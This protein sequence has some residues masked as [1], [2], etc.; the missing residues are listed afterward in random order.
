MSDG[1]NV[2]YDIESS[3]LELS[4]KQQFSFTELVAPYC[5]KIDFQQKTQLA[6]R[7]WP[8]GKDHHIVVDPHHSFGRPVIT[9]TNITTDAILT[10]LKANE[11]PEFIASIYN[12]DLSEV[13]DVEL[14]MS[15]NAA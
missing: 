14:F 13:K 2:F 9:G 6:E 1:N 12:L 15:L 11:N 4:E 8:L 10:M 5:K 7:F 3:L